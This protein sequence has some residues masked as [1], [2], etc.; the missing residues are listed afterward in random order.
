M[1][2][3]ACFPV[4]PDSPR[5]YTAVGQFKKAKEVLIQFRGS[6]APDVED[7]CLEICALEADSKPTS[8]LQFAK[9]LMGRCAWLCLWLQIMA[10]WSGIT[11]ITARSP[12]LLIQAGYSTIKQNS[13]AGRPEYHWDSRYHH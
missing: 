10:S 6:F 12:V 5:F 1:A 8:P 9:V 7:E 11:A 4:L 3:S 13:L 2:L